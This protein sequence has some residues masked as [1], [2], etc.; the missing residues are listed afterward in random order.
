MSET[1]CL[2]DQTPEPSGKD[3]TPPTRPAHLRAVPE[4]RLE[5]IE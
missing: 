3:P 4:R 1:P 2:H 5:P